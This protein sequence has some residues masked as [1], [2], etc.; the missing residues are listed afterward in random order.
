MSCPFYRRNWHVRT[1]QLRGARNDT[2][3]DTVKTNELEEA[4]RVFWQNAVNKIWIF[5]C[6][7]LSYLW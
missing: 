3:F 7:F 4:L 6:F 1:W 2:W 5:S